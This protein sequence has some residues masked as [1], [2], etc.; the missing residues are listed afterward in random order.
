M[1]A[2]AVQ[3]ANGVRA[4]TQRQ[5]A[6]RVDVAAQLRTARAVDTRLRAW[7][8][9]LLGFVSVVVHL[10]ASRVGAPA[11]ANGAVDLKALMANLS[12]Q[13]L[14]GG[15]NPHGV[16][17]VVETNL[18]WQ[19]G[20]RTA[21]PL[22]ACPIRQRTDALP[23][24]GSSE[25]PTSSASA[26]P[27]TPVLPVAARVL[28]C[29]AADTH[30]AGVF[31]AGVGVAPDESL[32]G[33]AHAC[34]ALEPGADGATP[35]AARAR[36][37]T[38]AVI[39]PERAVSEAVRQRHRA[40][41]ERL[42]RLPEAVDAWR[43]GGGEDG[44]AGSDTDDVG[45]D[46]GR[47]PGGGA[48]ARLGGRG[49]PGARSGVVAPELPPPPLPPGVMPVPTPRNA[50]GKALTRILRHAPPL[51]S[52]A[53]PG[54]A[55]TAEPAC[56]HYLV[57]VNT[58]CPP[59]A[60]PTGVFSRDVPPGPCWPG[61]RP[62]DYHHERFSGEAASRRCAA[63]PAGVALHAGAQAD[64]GSWG[65]AQGAAAGAS[66]ARGQHGPG[67]GDGEPDAAGYGTWPP[68]VS[69]PRLA[70]LPL[71]DGQP[72]L[73][74]RRWARAWQPEGNVSE[75]FPNLIWTARGVWAEP[76]QAPMGEQQ[77]A[78]NAWAC[79]WRGGPGQADAAEPDALGSGNGRD[80]AHDAA[81]CER[82]PPHSYRNADPAGAA[83]GARPAPLAPPW[84]LRYVAVPA[85]D[86]P[87]PSGDDG[88][89]PPGG[90][91]SGNAR[92]GRSIGRKRA[93]DGS[94]RRSLG[95]P[96]PG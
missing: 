22:S 63:P 21:A 38:A 77:R 75:Y 7:R 69:E 29:V 31:E 90:R 12:P 49:A 19:S 83:I 28:G 18:L 82:A 54:S 96:P 55:G 51:T 60:A 88:A 39:Q 13:A 5:L 93:G 76:E 62:S 47:Q 72:P 35:T 9:S 86:L 81:A 92:R 11:A 78:R 80:G 46:H 65:H 43:V 67:A 94:R 25:G 68:S 24:V 45:S 30:A 74:V 50:L 84:R 56:A 33:G 40:L 61:M 4:K 48:D 1:A 32:C 42:A 52:P 58:G 66:T 64:A 10:R 85:L 16:R 36:L 27:L 95:V 57:V 37:A 44:G 89:S 71:R 70:P 87:A 53:G 17:H 20:G 6:A 8:A 3:T 2:G 79:A 14:E 26:N 34:A 59:F 73:D 91:R 23:A 41:R 15:I